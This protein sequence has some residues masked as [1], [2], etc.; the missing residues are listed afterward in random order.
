MVTFA[1]KLLTAHCLLTT[2]RR[3]WRCHICA[4]CG[5]LYT[6]LDVRPVM[7]VSARRTDTNPV[8]SPRSTPCITCTAAI[9]FSLR[10]SANSAR[11]APLR[12]AA[13]AI[14]CSPLPLYVVFGTNTLCT[15]S[16]G[17]VRRPACVMTATAV[18]GVGSDHRASPYLRCSTGGA[19]APPHRISAFAPPYADTLSGLHTLACRESRWGAKK[20]GTAHEDIR[21]PAWLCASILNGG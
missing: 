12:G 11:V 17:I 4:G 3:V 2:A 9:V 1:Q 14:V 15:A 19:V 18:C 21:P 6:A 16:V 13:G 7:S 20:V 8:R 10:E 5:R